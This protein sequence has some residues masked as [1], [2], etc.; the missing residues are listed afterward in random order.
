MSN[1][2]AFISYSHSDQP[3][4][5]RLQR[6][7]ES[8]RVPGQIVKRL[9]L[10]SNRLTPIFRDVSDLAAAPGLT[11]ALKEA[12]RRSAALIV[13]CSPSAAAS[14]WVDQEIEAYRQEHGD[15]A[16][17]L[18]IITST[19]ADGSHEGLFPS[20]LSGSIPLAADA[21]P[22]SEGYRL[23][24]L[25]LVAGLLGIGLDELVQREA[26]R[27]YR[28]MSAGSATSLVIAVAMGFLAFQAIS[29]RDAA[30]RRLSQS[31]DLIG[32]MLGDLRSQLAPLGQ[33]KVLESVGEK[34]LE[35][36]ASLEAEDQTVAARLRQSKALYQIGDVYFEL[37]KFGAA[38]KSFQLSLNQARRLAAENPSDLDRL[39]ELSQ[40]EFWVAFAAW[41]GGD[42]LV[43]ETH[44]QLYHDTAWT[45]HQREPENPDWIME[46]FW[47][48]N[49]LGSLA[50]RNRRYEEARTYFEDAIARIEPLIDQG[51]SPERRLEKSA[52]LSW[53]G[54]THY[55]LGDLQLSHQAFE[56]ALAMQLDPADATHQ[57]ER[58]FQFGKLARVEWYLGE[59]D[60]SLECALE[61]V[62][63]AE[64][65]HRSDPASMER[66][67]AYAYQRFYALSFS[68]GAVGTDQ[69]SELIEQ[70]KTL[71]STDSPPTKWYSLAAQAAA[72]GANQKDPAAISWGN[73]LLD[74]NVTY[75][76]LLNDEQH[77]LLELAT[78]ITQ[79]DTSRDQRTRSLMED[80][81]EVFQQSADFGLALPLLRAYQLFGEQDRAREIMNLMTGKG[82][83]HP[84]LDSLIEWRSRKTG[85]SE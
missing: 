77:H 50:F 29:A 25:K 70:I 42:L 26:K 7:L 68:A 74:S 78:A 80:T 2:R 34:A 19:S 57:E 56:R 5:I 18:P 69:Y 14:S 24:V 1:Y 73:E 6:S 27:R 28:R 37:G 46:V 10:E 23:A 20:G 79:Y 63:I 32:F 30:Q 84:E 33:V 21:R 35:Y 61:G 12:L 38:R 53:L 72:A 16:L 82:W 3:F 58:A 75:E 85:A 8:Y 36:F 44:F 62:K 66:L 47:A 64:R 67:Y 39:F 11:E 76:A 17:I 55:R 81:A 48:D 54:S 22:N 4:A 65:L 31:E 45:L 13:I 15:R 60:S 71:L 41:Y 51:S 40:A 83:R 43:A 52:T 49:N 9:E 59:S